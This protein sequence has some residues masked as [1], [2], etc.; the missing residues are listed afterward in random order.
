VDQP[1]KLSRQEDEGGGEKVWG[2]NGESCGCRN[3]EWAD[4]TKLTALLLPKI[5]D[6]ILRDELEGKNLGLLGKKPQNYCF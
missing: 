2:W 6:K 4:S 5:T 1:A 3:Q